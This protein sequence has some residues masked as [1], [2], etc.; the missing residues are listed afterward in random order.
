DSLPAVGQT[1]LD[2]L[3]PAGSLRK[4]SEVQSLHPVLLS[5]ACLAQSH[6]PKYTMAARNTLTG[7]R[8][9]SGRFCPHHACCVH[10]R[11]YERLLSGGGEL[12][13]TNCCPS[14]NCLPRKMH[15]RVGPQRAR[16]FGLGA[17]VD[18]TEASKSATPRSDDIREDVGYS[19]MQRGT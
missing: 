10:P 1:L 6:R 7:G 5:Q 15:R 12:A 2:G 14:L 17:E 3:L 13:F 9:R 11:R 8:P 18:C 16:D 19:A 4:V